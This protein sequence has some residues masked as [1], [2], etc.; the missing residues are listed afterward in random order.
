[1]R[2]VAIA[3]EYTALAAALLRTC[4]YVVVLH[5]APAVCVTRRGTIAEGHTVLTAALLAYGRHC[6]RGVAPNDV[7]MR[8]L[9][10][11]RPLCMSQEEAQ[12]QKET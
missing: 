8:I 1:M 5:K 6:R 2:E 7:C 3:A 11:G 4:A 9:Y 10:Y 12:R